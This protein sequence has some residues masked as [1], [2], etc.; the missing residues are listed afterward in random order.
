MNR[1]IKFHLPDA[2]SNKSLKKNTHHLA[3]REHATRVEVTDPALVLAIDTADVVRVL[4]PATEGA[5]D[6][7]PNRGL[8]RAIVV[9]GAVDLGH[10][11]DGINH[12]L[13]LVIVDDE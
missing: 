1:G 11:T 2:K 9:H 12:G 5:T 7:V 4:D 13:D 6:L 8:D 3:L 10:V